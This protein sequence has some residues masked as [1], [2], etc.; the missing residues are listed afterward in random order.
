MKSHFSKTHAALFLLLQEARNLPANAVPS[1]VV[2]RMQAQRDQI[3]KD[4]CVESLVSYERYLDLFSLRL[5]DKALKDRLT[6]LDPAFFEQTLAQDPSRFDLV[7]GLALCWFRKGKFAQGRTLLQRVA[8]SGYRE[9]RLASRLL[10]AR[11]LQG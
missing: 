9:R 1:L 10:A 4:Y 8:A 3:A 7:V 6:L 2:G 5:A 11:V